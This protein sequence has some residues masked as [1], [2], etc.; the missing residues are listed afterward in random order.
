MVS[1]LYK[2]VLDANMSIFNAFNEEYEQRTKN[3]YTKYLQPFV[4]SFLSQ[5]KGKRIV[6][7]G[8]GP[9]RDLAY[10]TSKGYDAYGIDGSERMIANCQEKGFR[11]E[12]ADFASIHLNNNSLDGVWAYTSLT[13][14]PQDMFENVLKKLTEALEKDTGVLALGMI[15]G[16]GEAW[17]QDHKYDGKKRFVARYSRQSL[18]QILSKYF[19]TVSIEEVTD[20]ENENRK[21]YHIICKNTTPSK[22]E[23]AGQAAKTLFNKFA[24]VYESRTQT[25]IA[26]LEEDRNQFISKISSGGKILDLGCG[27]GRDAIIFKNAGYEVTCFDISEKN[28]ELC[29]QKGLTGYVG[30]MN[31]L[32][33]YFGEDTFDGV[34]ANCSL[35]NWIPKQNLPNILQ[36]IKVM[37]KKQA[38]VFL[39]SI[40]GNFTGW[41]IDE[42]YDTL[43]RYNTHWLLQELRQEIDVLGECIYER[44]IPTEKSKRK[45][46][47]NTIHIIK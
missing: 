22:P 36:Q 4:D 40:L 46:Y 29:E 37:A 1:S 11:V 5:L 17:K 25:G 7:L 43:P 8:C 32:L 44:K 20:P 31:S 41:E 6:D 27:P 10:F 30:D 39:G 3:A 26:L 45:D 34:W 18:E 24:D 16:D 23:E 14:V 28:I 12:Q 21:Y 42:K 47:Y 15:D 19:G 2:E 33:K 35:T 9:G 38:P 13:L